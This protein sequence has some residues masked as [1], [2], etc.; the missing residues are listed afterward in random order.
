M[1]LE[2][3]L[4]LTL[5]EPW[6][7]VPVSWAQIRLCSLSSRS[8]HVCVSDVP[9][10]REW[11]APEDG[12]GCSHIWGGFRTWTGAG[13]RSP[14][15]PSPRDTDGSWTS[16]A[17]SPESSWESLPQLLEINQMCNFRETPSHHA[18]LWLSTLSMANVQRASPRT[19]NY[20][21][22]FTVSD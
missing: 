16:A 12:C 5:R 20:R 2:E 1:L 6:H 22:K 15:T 4:F 3:R 19:C 18:V 10:I 9:S 11:S 7:N 21:V 13:R 14:Q 8:L 17:S